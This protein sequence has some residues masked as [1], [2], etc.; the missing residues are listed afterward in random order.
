MNISC[1]DFAEKEIFNFFLSLL[2]QKIRNNTYLTSLNNVT[3]FGLKHVLGLVFVHVQIIC[4]DQ[5]ILRNGVKSFLK[6]HIYHYVLVLSQ[7][8]FKTFSFKIPPV[9]PFFRWKWFTM[10][11]LCEWKYIVS[12]YIL[13]KYCVKDI[14]YHASTLWMNIY[15]M[16]TLKVLCE[17][18]M[19]QSM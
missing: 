19:L 10:F 16:Y 13:W 3:Q 14:I 9:I 11:V 7:D 15:C 8:I 1:R 5:G 12:M 18:G 17:R 4:Q 6:D 2:C